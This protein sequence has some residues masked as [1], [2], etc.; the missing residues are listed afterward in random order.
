M[1][2]TEL[3]RYIDHTLLK[4][5]ATRQE[6]HQLVHEALAFETF[7]VC[8]NSGYVK[9]AANARGGASGLAIAAT[10]GFPLG[11]SLTA[12]K[13][14]ETRAALDAEADEI[15]LVWNLGLFLS[16]DWDR[17]E[18]DIRAV[19]S[20]AGPVPVK[21][22]LETAR[23]EPEQIR[24]GARLAVTAGAHTVKTSTGFGFP[25]ATRDAVAVLRDTVGPHIGV[26][27]SGGIRTYE[28]ALMM[29]GAGATRLGVSRTATILAGAEE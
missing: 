6:I 29:I 25:G 14:A 8:V 22:I 17:V 24:R 21:V 18:T 1:K 12:A 7:A 10:V 27:A 23:L 16:D 26:K 20:E 5:D 15:D 2:R 28:D 9:D 11:Q 4:A 13:V 3:A 19:V